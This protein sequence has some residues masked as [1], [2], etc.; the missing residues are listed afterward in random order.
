MI[1]LDVGRREQGKTTL[2]WSMIQ[3]TRIRLVFDPRGMI[4]GDGRCETEHDVSNRMNLIQQGKADQLIYTP[5]EDVGRGFE[6][7]ARRMRKAAA[8]CPYDLGIL[9]DE[10][11]FV[12][13]DRAE[14]LLWV[15]RCAS[16]QRVHIVFTAHR[17][18]D[19]ST[20]VRAI[21]DYWLLFPMRQEH[22]LRVIDERCGDHV[23][24]IVQ[25]LK[26]REFV[27]WDDTLGTF[28]VH[29]QPERWYVPLNGTAGPTAAGPLLNLPAD[30]DRDGGLPFEGEPVS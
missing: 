1:Y 15:L 13:T 18:S 9:I 21:A 29:K 17:P 24:R 8:E 30:P 14:D 6:V 4:G 10:A 11:A 27:M 5:A 19:I 2:A 23:V 25:K 26:A 22:D 3:K 20:K 28:T 12:D 16:R 7:F